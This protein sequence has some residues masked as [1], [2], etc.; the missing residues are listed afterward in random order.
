MVEI[1]QLAGHQIKG[2]GIDREITTNQI[3]RQWSGLH[4]GVFRWRG[5]ALLPSRGQVQRNAIQL[6]RHGAESSV[7][8]HSAETI[9][10]ATSSQLRGERGCLPL[11]NP[12]Q[13]RN[14]SQSPTKALMQKLITNRAAHQSQPMHTNRDGSLPQLLQQPIRHTGQIHL[15]AC[16]TME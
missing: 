6:Q 2:H 13:I 11:H 12:I 3:S 1:N 14:A 7:F 9:W 4:H 5:V 10:A 8:L 15:G 16:K